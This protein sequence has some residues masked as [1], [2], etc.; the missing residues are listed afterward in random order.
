MIA[1]AHQF[2]QAY[3]SLGWTPIP[4][5]S[6]KG[7]ACTCGKANCTAVGKHPRIARWQKAKMPSITELNTWPAGNI[8][9]LTGAPSGFFALDVD[10]RH[11]GTMS[12]RELVTAHGKLPPT[13]TATTGGGGMHILFR[14]PTGKKIENRAG[15]RPGLDIRGDGGQIVVAPSQ[16]LAPYS[17]RTPTGQPDAPVLDAPDWLLKIIIGDKPRTP[18]S[19]ISTGF[20]PNALDKVGKGRRN[21]FLARACGWLHRNGHRD[22]ALRERLGSINQSRCDPPLDESEVDSI[23]RSI[24]TRATKSIATTS[25]HTAPISASDLL[26][27]TFPPVRWI[28]PGILPAGLTLLAGKPKT[29][30]SWLAYDI[31][32]AVATGTAAL[33]TSPARQGDVLYLALE[34]NERRLQL[35]LKNLRQD[36]QDA[37]SPAR[38][39][40]NTQCPRLDQGAIENIR[41]WLH[42]HKD[43]SLVIVD[44]LA[45]LR[46]QRSKNSDLY[47]DDYAAS[48]ALKQLADEFGI[49]VLVVT[50]NR[51]ADAE[52]PMDLISGTLGLAGGADGVLILR[53]KRGDKSA[54]LFV[55]GRDIEE[56]KDYGIEFQGCRWHVVG[57]ARTVQLSAQRQSVIGLLKS[58]NQPMTVA[59]ITAGI[60]GNNSA[61]RKLIYRMHQEGDLTQAKDRKHYSLSSCPSSDTGPTSHMS[62]TGPTTVTPA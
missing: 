26:T 43:T 13:L 31:A 36:R 16:T 11:G 60:G 56:E 53:R 48:S 55:T 62:P 1:S 24:S 42:A 37:A 52:D 10:P 59:E 14:I 39:Y 28:V 35:R 38:L 18:T 5:H 57:D 50:H 19:S 3:R 33:T 23:F 30:K 8:G 17:W 4:L 46:A 2:L 12:L 47:G 58:T 20:D 7:N 41:N 44:T 27:R 9:I 61:T 6:A 15:F 21:D 25:V 54:A 29:G 22:H 34:D 40:L 49:S 32:Y 51:K 45:K